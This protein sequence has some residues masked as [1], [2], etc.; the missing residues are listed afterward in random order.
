[1]VINESNKLIDWFATTFE[2]GRGFDPHIQ[3]HCFMEI[4]HE[5]ISM[6]ILSL[7][8]IQEEKLSVTGERMCTK[9]W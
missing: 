7:L 2:P 8:L 4:G 9:Y 3:Q 5:I 1:M 6:V